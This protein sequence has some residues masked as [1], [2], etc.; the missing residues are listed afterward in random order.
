MSLFLKLARRFVSARR[1]ARMEN[2]LDQR[3]TFVVPVF[4]NLYKA[5]NGAAVIRTCDALGI[6]KAHFIEQESEFSI[7]RAVSQGSHNWVEAV[8]HANIESCFAHLRRQGYRLVVTSLEPDACTPDELPLDKPL[9]IIFGNEKA[10]ISAA[11]RNACDYSVAYPMHG[12]VDSFNVSVAAALI[13]GR[14]LERLR[15]L[16]SEQW[17]LSPRARKRTLRRW[18]F[19]NTRVGQIVLVSRRKGRLRDNP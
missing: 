18:L 17:A 3:T 6:N 10:G 4:E 13:L 7:Y 16:P 15:T 2:I 5:H 1:L 14:L 8:S 9:A 19:H 12:F 11:V